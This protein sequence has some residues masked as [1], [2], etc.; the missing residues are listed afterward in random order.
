[1][2]R[3]LIVNADDF[4]IG[5]RISDAIVES[6]RLGIVTSTTLMVNMPAAVYASQLAGNAP[7]L[8]VGVHLTLTA[9]HAV[10]PAE[11]IPALVDP[12]GRFHSFAVQSRRLSWDWRLQPQVEAEFCGQIEKALDLGVRPT[13][14]DSHHGVT[15]FPVVRSALIRALDKY[16]I[17]RARAA[18]GYYWVTN[19]AS[20]SSRA[21]CVAR[22]LLKL[23]WQLVLMS[24]R[25][26]LARHGI[27]TPHHL[28]NPDLRLPYE[29]DPR[30]R[31]LAALAGLP[32]GDSELTLH[33]GRPDP[34]VDDPPGYGMK[35]ERDCELALDPESRRIL[36]QSGALLIS[37]RDL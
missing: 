32:D 36:E 12:Q 19:G 5:R 9:G 28:V 8:G 15:K 29:V 21:R 4:G 17:S 30:T 26:A 18:T 6:H 20:R 16:G 1:M 23:P 34:D 37:F 33:P 10:T 25:S 3:R 2:T 11:R 22:N 13:H 7:T 14:C 24:N 35:R 31:F 27:K